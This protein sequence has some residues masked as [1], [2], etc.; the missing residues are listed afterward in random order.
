MPAHY[1]TLSSVTS[2][3]TAVVQQSLPKANLGTGVDFKREG[4]KSSL[5]AGSLGLVTAGKGR[6]CRLFTGHSSLFLTSCSWGSLRV[7]QAE[8]W[9]VQQVS[10]EMRRRSPSLGTEGW[11]KSLVVLSRFPPQNLD[12]LP[13][14]QGC[15]SHEE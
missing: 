13:H 5:A 8:V 3:K 2:G 14:A 1:L 12:S 11:V 4:K 10:Q 15:R 6:P 9:C 7:E